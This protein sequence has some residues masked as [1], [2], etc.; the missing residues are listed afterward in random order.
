MRLSLFYNPLVIIDR[1]AI[2]I[3]R[4]KRK[5]RLKG[6]PADGLGL[7]YL[8]SLELLEL[9]KKDG[10]KPGVIFDIGANIGTWTVLAKSLF[11][12]AATHGFE[13]LKNHIQQFEKNIKGLSNAHIHTFCLGDENK[14]M[15]I[16]VT[17]F[18]DA[19][20]I[21]DVAPL[22][23]EQFN[24]KKSSEEKIE[25][26]RLETLIDEGNIPVPDVMK[27]DVQGYELEVLKGAGKYLHQVSYLIVE[28]SFKEYYQKQALFLDI[29]NYLAS[30]H[31]GIYAFGQSTPLGSELGQI[32]VLFRKEQSA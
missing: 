23:Y 15:T 6:T 13:P 19:S 14:G 11:P 28:V 30:H 3:N 9:I 31:I 20:S 25:V 16:N 1:L 22:V 8:D 12:E 5:N 4:R 21:L 32:D 18:S 2:A 26:K 24:I 17:S 10:F 27:L 29:A 7:G